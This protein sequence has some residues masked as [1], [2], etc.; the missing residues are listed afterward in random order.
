MALVVGAAL[1]A[2]ASPQSRWEV[3]RVG[4]VETRRVVSVP[5]SDEA[6][7][8]YAF[9]AAGGL[10]AANQRGPRKIYRYGIRT[11]NN[12]VV[13]IEWPEDLQ[14]GICVAVLGEAN[15]IGGLT[16]PFPMGKVITSTACK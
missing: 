14:T 5:S 3:H 13:E 2:C 1:Y 8:L 12:E 10:L 9:G 7:W 15:D 11:S 6:A 16:Y 4:Q